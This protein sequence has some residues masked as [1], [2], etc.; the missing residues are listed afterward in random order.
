M[1]LVSRERQQVRLA[2][3]D[4]LIEFHA[5]ETIH[6]ESSYK[7]AAGKVEALLADAGFAPTGCW[8]DAREWFAVCLGRVE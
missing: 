2:A 5:G 1:H 8:T 7:Y 6:T 3:L 4:L